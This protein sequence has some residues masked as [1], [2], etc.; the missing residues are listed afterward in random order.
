MFVR[1]VHQYRPFESGPGGRAHRQGSR[2]ALAAFLLLLPAFAFISNACGGDDDD[3]GSGT[4]GKTAADLSP[5]LK[6]LGFTVAQ[7]GKAAGSTQNQDAYTTQYAGSGGKVTAART[8]INLH[9]S[10]DAATQQYNAI[11]EAL[12]NPPPDLFGANATQDDNT[13]L[14][15]ADQGKSYKTTK[16]DSQGVRVFTDV[17]RMG[18]AVVIVY[19]IGA[20]GA[21]TDAV[22]KKAAEEIS[23]KAPK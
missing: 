1:P 4:A 6:S 20:D 17:Y 8:D 19:V 18:R 9:P 7:S 10:V 16:A 21:D 23:S 15:K 5:D 22:R 11:S 13:T 12:R 2:I 14:F 3:A